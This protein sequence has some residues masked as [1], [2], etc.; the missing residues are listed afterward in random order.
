MFH[1]IVVINAIEGAMIII[2]VLVKVM[3]AEQ[4]FPFLTFKFLQVIFAC[5]PIIFSRVGLRLR[6]D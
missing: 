6:L 3:V 5:R 2:F 1:K 4:T